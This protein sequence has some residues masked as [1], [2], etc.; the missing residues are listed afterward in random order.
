M[1]TKAVK[2]DET[3]MEMSISD[4]ILYTHKNISAR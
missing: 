2:E 1:A 4:G 3:W